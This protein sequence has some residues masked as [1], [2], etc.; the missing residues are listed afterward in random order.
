MHIRYMNEK[1]VYLHSMVLISYRNTPGI[2]ILL[3]C[4]RLSTSSLVTV[5][6]RYPQDSSENNY[7]GH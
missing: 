2:L 6:Y 5:G 7:S 1:P 3:D 4:H